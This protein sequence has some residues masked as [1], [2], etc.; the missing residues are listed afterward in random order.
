MPF[1]L[2]NP[3]NLTTVFEITDFANEMTGYMV[4]PLVLIAIFSI[5]N[6]TFLSSGR[7][8]E[9]SILASLWLT[10]LSGFL[11]SLIPNMINAEIVIGLLIVT[12]LSSIFL[13]KGQ[14]S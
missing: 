6:I 14:R 1:E 2:Q 8:K 13:F 10:S 7:N 11:L 12:A 9:D 3:E 4:G 5:S